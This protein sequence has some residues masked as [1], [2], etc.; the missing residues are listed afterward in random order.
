[1]RI[2]EQI[3]AVVLCAGLLLPAA[4]EPARAFDPEKV[5]E[6]QK[7]SPLALWK[8]FF[9]ARK[10]GQEE[11]AIDVL[12]YAAE[13]GSHA[14]QWK[15]GRMYQTGDGVEKNAATAFSFY[16]Q[17]V[18]SYTDARPGT[19]DWQFTANAMVVVGRYYRDGL[20][21]AGIARNPVE[22]QVMFTTAATY[23][24][25][26]DAQYELARM[27]LEGENSRYDGIQAARML[28]AAADQGHVGAEALLGQLLYDGKYL[29]R[30]PVRGLSMMMNARRR[31]TGADAGWISALQEEAFALASEDE[32]RAAVALVQ[33]VPATQ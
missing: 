31:A 16:K 3:A 14:A 24:D 18:D 9:S 29:R 5:F 8:Y 7:P 26:P 22:A 30:D 10:K 21:E 15:L 1:M 32:R 23:F 6:G 11:E 2:S 20:P 27:Y 12:R 13:Q 33:S 19:P 25:H 28:K 4:A 17:V